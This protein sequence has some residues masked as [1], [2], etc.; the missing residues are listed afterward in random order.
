VQKP[1]LK[2]ELTG[3][4]SPVITA[5]VSVLMIAVHNRAQ[6]SSDNLYSYHP[7]NHRSSHVVHWDGAEVLGLGIELLPLS[8][9]DL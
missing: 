8:L 4:S 7:H 2:C 6:D 1:K 3:A 9:T 5:H